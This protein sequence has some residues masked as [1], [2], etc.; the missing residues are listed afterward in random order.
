M[1]INLFFFTRVENV[2]AT[3]FTVTPGAGII[4]SP[5]ID[6][7]DHSGSYCMV[8]IGNIVRVEMDLTGRRR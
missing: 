5:T 6:S 8:T 3:C 4:G 2:D 1:G 7:V